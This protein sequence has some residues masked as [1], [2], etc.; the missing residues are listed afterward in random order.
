MPCGAIGP[1]R[2]ETGALVDRVL[3]RVFVAILA[4]EEGQR[5]ERGIGKVWEGGGRVRTKVGWRWK[6]TK[7]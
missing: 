4:S 2:S 5:Y 6:L 1:W 7:C 3:S